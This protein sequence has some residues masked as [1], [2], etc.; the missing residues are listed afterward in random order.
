MPVV[1]TAV[2]GYGA[3]LKRPVRIDAIGAYRAGATR[4]PQ[5]WLDAQ[6]LEAADGLHLSWDAMERVFAPD[7]LADMFGGFVARVRRLAELPEAWVAPPPGTVPAPLRSANATAARLPWEPV[8]A[9]ILRQAETAPQREAVIAQDRRLDFATLVGEAT[10]L[11][12]RIQAAGV[13]QGQ[14]VGVVMPKGWRQVVAVLAI[15]LAGAA[16]V[17]VEL[18]LPP[19]RIRSLLQRAGVALALT[20]AAPEG[21][22]WPCAATDLDTL[23]AAAPLP[24]RPCR[25]AA[26]DLA[27]VLFTSGS[28]GEPK[29]VAL[30][31]G[32]VSNTLHDVNGRFGVGPEDRVLGLSSLGFD[33]SVWDIFGVLGAGGALVLPAAESV[34]DPAHLAALLAREQVTLWNSTPS[35]LKLVVEAPGIALAGSLRLLMLSGDWIPLPLARRLR[36]EYPAARLVSLGGATEAAIW[37]IWHPVDR[38]EEGWRSVPYGRAMANQRF[39]V[40]DE[41]QRACPIG[42]VGQLHIGGAGLAA[43]Y[44]RDEASTAASFIRH[45]ETGE[46]LY[47]TGDYGRVLADGGI[48]SSAAGTPK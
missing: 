32:A 26:S 48:D 36:A 11:A 15:G 33:L 1:F 20:H 18:P 43:G 2:H 5:V 40:L 7:I 39:Y 42:E 34:R 45:P 31:H 17:P 23:V 47:R 27:Y 8:F 16:Y 12:A 29:G 25:P 38:V 9:G 30:Q 37:S 4:T 35:Y 46:R 13:V 19:A 10:M 3:L 22:D 6:S 28:T 41:A 21:L 44:W 24:W 14:L